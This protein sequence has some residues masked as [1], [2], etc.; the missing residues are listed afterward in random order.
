MKQTNKQTNWSKTNGK[1][2]MLNNIKYLSST[3]IIV[4]IFA[5]ENGSISILNFHFHFFSFRRR[6]KKFQWKWISIHCYYYYCCY[7]CILA[8][9]GNYFIMNY[10]HFDEHW[11]NEHICGSVLVRS[12]SIVEC[13]E[14]CA[15]RWKM[16]HFFTHLHWIILPPPEKRYAITVRVNF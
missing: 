2:N 16:F 3:M 11:T 1:S 7:H 15:Q 12:I 8:E 14:I 9:W 4:I 13:L 6:R 5:A 10:L